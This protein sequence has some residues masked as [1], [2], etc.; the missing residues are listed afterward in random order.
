[1][2]V[3]GSGSVLEIA[4]E[5]TYGTDVTKT[6]SVPF[7]SEGFELTP[8]FAKSA[9]MRNGNS[10]LVDDDIRRTSKTVEGEVTFDLY[11][12][13]LLEWFHSVYGSDGYTFGAGSPNTHTFLVGAQSASHDSLC[14]DLFVGGNTS[15]LEK[16]ITGIIANGYSVSAAAGDDTPIQI[17]F[18]CSGQDVAGDTAQTAAGVEVSGLESFT[19]AGVTVTLNSVSCVQGFSMDVAVPKEPRWCLG[20]TT[21]QKPDRSGMATVTGTVDLFFSDWTEY[22]EMVAGTTSALNITA[23]EIGAAST[24]H[25]YA[26]TN[27]IYF[28]GGTPTVDSPERVEVTMNWEAVGTTPGD[29][30]A[31]AHQLV[32]SS[33][34][35]TL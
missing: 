29:Q 15:V 12:K 33:T 6:T 31:S 13:G 26:W 9:G 30:D 4:R 16:K 32:V 25:Q 3:N 7:V 14:A 11:D 5:S 34:D 35:A 17:S 2:T 20:S 22:N 10:M 23:A 28:T 18:S 8:G 19:W 27:N 21:Q 1:M 24:N